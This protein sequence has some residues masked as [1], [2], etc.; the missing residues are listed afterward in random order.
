[1]FSEVFLAMTGA[2]IAQYAPK[3]AAYMACH[4]SAYGCGLSNPPERLPEGSLLLLD[5]STPIA[6]HDPQTVAD[7][8]NSL[9]EIFPLK[10]ILLDFQRPP[11]VHARRMAETLLQ[12][13]SAPVAV[14]E[15][16]CR[17]LDCPVFLGPPPVNKSLH[18]HLLPYTK[19]GVYLEIAPESRRFTITA[20]GSHKSVLPR[21]APPLPLYDEKLMCHYRVEVSTDRAVFTLSRTQEDLGALT[22]QAY[23]LG[24]LGVVGLY[25]ELSETPI[26]KPPAT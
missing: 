15:N 20:T 24:V 14:T 16:Y 13:V 5:D 23:E 26:E 19:R 18:A 11:N 10:A 2:E 1:M 9:A 6:G 7:Q 17:D 25:Q 3:R 8:L 4:F 22:R 12:A 21:S